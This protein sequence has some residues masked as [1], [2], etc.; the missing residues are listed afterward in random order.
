MDRKIILI[1]LTLIAVF[2]S[3]GASYAGLPPGFEVFFNYAVD[4]DPVDLESG[5]ADLIRE[6]ESEIKASLYCLTSAAIIQAFLEASEK[7]GPTGIRIIVDSEH[8]DNEAL[9]PLYEAGISIIDNSCPPG[10]YPGGIMHNKFV[11]TDSR[12]IW[13]GSYNTTYNGAYLNSNNSVLVD[14]VD[15]A[16]E[17]ESEFDQMWGT[18][19]EGCTGSKF[20][21]AKDAHEN[22]EFLI[23]ETRV[24]AY[25]GPPDA[26]HSAFLEA[27]ENAEKSI[28]FC[29]YYFTDFEMAQAIAEA[30]R[31]GIEVKGVMDDAGATDFGTQFNYLDHFDEVEMRNYKQDVCPHARTLHHKFMVIDQGMPELDPIVIT[32]SANWTS[33]GQNHNDENVLFIYSKEFA[34]VYYEEFVRCFHGTNEEEEPL[35]T[36]YLNQS[37]YS[38]GDEFRLSVKVQNTCDFLALDLYVLLDCGLDTFWY[39]PGWE[40]EPDWLSY[41]IEGNGGKYEKTILEFNMPSKLSP[42]GPFHFHAGI[43]S[44]GT[45]EPLGPF[46]SIPF[47]LE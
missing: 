25:F 24:E 36:L 33:N 30:A 42:A 35:T 16:S 37:S 18:V 15:L 1:I 27:I 47:Y 39:W 21:T 10:S 46:F 38:G 31:S 20:G 45:V 23:G 17:Y 7:I 19:P 13:T 28:H 9:T 14:D 40:T 6:A 34:D 29:I 11:V 2:I 26:L 44:Q 8:S 5:L 4:R 3:Y 12:H 41:D 22:N 43:F 32:G